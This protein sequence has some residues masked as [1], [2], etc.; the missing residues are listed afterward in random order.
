[1]TT[2]R[3]VLAGVFG[4]G[5][6]TSSPSLGTSDQQVSVEPGD[7]LAVPDNGARPQ[8]VGI[9]RYAMGQC[10]GT[11]IASNKVLTAAHCTG[12]TPENLDVY[13]DLNSSPALE[14]SLLDLDDPSIFAQEEHIRWKVLS[15]AKHP[16]HNS[17]DDFDVDIAVLTMESSIPPGLIAPMPIL[18]DILP[19]PFIAGQ[20]GHDKW[21][22]YYA[23]VVGMGDY[24]P[25]CGEAAFSPAMQIS[26]EIVDT[27]PG[28]NF[29]V[30]LSWLGSTPQGSMT[31]LGDS[32]GPFITRVPDF[33]GTTNIP[34]GF[35]MGVLGGAD[36]DGIS[37]VGPLMTA[38]NRT[39]VAQ[40]ALD[41]DNDGIEVPFDTCDKQW[42]PDQATTD[43]DGD[44]WPDVNCDDDD[45]NDGLDDFIDNCDLIE[46]ADQANNDGDAN[47]DVCDWDDDGDFVADGEDN[48]PVIANTGQKNCNADAEKLGFAGSS[49]SKVL[50][51]AC[52]PVPCAPADIEQRDFVPHKTVFWTTG[53]AVCTTQTGR[54]YEDLVDVLGRVKADNPAVTT[55]QL[56][57]WFCGCEDDTLAE[58]KAAPWNCGLS[59]TAGTTLGSRWRKLSLTNLATPPVAISQPLST[60]FSPWNALPSPTVLRWDYLADYTTWIV[61]QNLW[62]PTPKD[63][64]IYGAGTN[65]MGVLWVE[66]PTSLGLSAHNAGGCSGSGC[67]MSSSYL[68]QTA[69]DR[70]VT[71][72]GCKQ[73]PRLEPARWWTYCAKCEDRLQLPWDSV[74]NPG[75][76][77]VN[78][79]R[80]HVF[81]QELNAIHGVATGNAAQVTE[82]FARSLV[83]AMATANV[84]GPSDSIT[85]LRPGG[86]RAV[87]LSNDGSRLLGEVFAGARQFELR[88]LANTQGVTPRTGFAVTYSLADATLRVAGGLAPTGAPRGDYWQWNR[89]SGWRQLPINAELAP[90]AAVS[91]VLAGDRAL[92][93]IDRGSA[94]LR[95]LRI[96]ET[97]GAGVAG[98]FTLLDRASEAWLFQ[99]ADGGVAMAT[100]ANGRHQLSR[101][102]VQGGTLRILSTRE[103]TGELAGAPS[104]A[105]GNV[106]VPLRTRTTSATGVTTQLVPA[107]ALSAGL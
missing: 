69:P 45:D 51:D 103:Y 97:T 81:S 33:I 61:N 94:G 89:S 29:G 68:T 66:D 88:S 58:C 10:T 16:L 3:L 23:D 62:T 39:F 48:C 18:A 42:N 43:T 5:A 106:A 57:I 91:T 75:F 53:E 76:V 104:V 59:P 7:P 87:A 46:N 63:P 78:D 98:T 47:G 19:A 40:Q 24:G 2:P 65:M 17:D 70:A 8:I 86:A 14:T 101:L 90:R 35:V 95:L 72:T 79:S 64:A 92:W 55:T 60:T 4:L 28:P 84:V 20:T 73:I 74:S 67:S 21:V 52:D 26:L 38:G 105:A 99:L 49:P 34:P 30:L 11:I 32:G 44:G 9:Q 100:S 71:L 77:S 36:D 54:M 83:D 93:V 12:S 31:C 56:E 50:G 82:L 15:I 102:S 6:C 25:N 107:A 96:D 41:A 80:V 22:A 27:S 1:M 13:L 37:A 85:M